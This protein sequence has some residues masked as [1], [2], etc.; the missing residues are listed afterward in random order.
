MRPPGLLAGTN[1]VRG[2][3]R[4]VGIGRHVHVGFSVP[5][6]IEHL[7]ILPPVI[8]GQGGRGEG[9][10]AG[11][12]DKWG[13]GLPLVAGGFVLCI[14][15]DLGEP[16][17][18]RLCS[19]EG[20]LVLFSGCRVRLRKSD[21]NLGGARRDSHV[22]PSPFLE[23]RASFFCPSPCLPSS[24]KPLPLRRKAG[25]CLCFSRHHRSARLAETVASRRHIS[26]RDRRGVA[27][28]GQPHRSRCFLLHTFCR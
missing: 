4:R 26:D 27:I 5:G 22:L 28:P 1:L 19:V 6:R 7:A 3:G 14:G 20:T 16:H 25:P 13:Q 8:S 11:S 23:P 18:C 24:Q 2:R 15:Q 9:G 10:G 17:P 21:W 12:A